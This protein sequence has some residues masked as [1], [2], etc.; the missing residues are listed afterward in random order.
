[1][2]SEGFKIADLVFDAE[3]AR[4]QQPAIVHCPS[5]RTL[6][7]TRLRESGSIS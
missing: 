2:F 5:D 4:I 7:K 6:S 3:Q 1:M